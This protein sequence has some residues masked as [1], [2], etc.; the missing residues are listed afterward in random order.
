MNKESAKKTQPTAVFEDIKSE[1]AELTGEDNVDAEDDDDD[2]DII[3]PAFK[4]NRKNEKLSKDL[5]PMVE[6]KEEVKK[7]S[8]TKAVPSA[9]PKKTDIEK[10]KDITQEFGN[11]GEIN[12]IKAEKKSTEGKIVKQGGVRRFDDDDK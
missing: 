3:A 10:P 12:N 6:K 8:M 5:K 7:V 9:A 1:F 11:L 2:D 4:K